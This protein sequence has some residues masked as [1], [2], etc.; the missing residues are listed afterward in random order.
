MLLPNATLLVWL[1]SQGLT[2]AKE[3]CAKGD[4]GACTVI[5]ADRD[6]QGQRVFRSINSC[7]ALLPSL[8]GK[9]V[10]TVEGLAKGGHHPVQQ[11]MTASYGSQCGFC[12]PGFIASLFE[13]Y[14]R[15]EILTNEDLNEQLCGNLCRCTWR[16]GKIRSWHAVRGTQKLFYRLPQN[17]SLFRRNS[18]RD[19]DLESQTRYSQAGK[20]VQGVQAQ[21]DGYQHCCRSVFLNTA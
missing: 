7:I 14:Y 18:P 3:G 12:T 6:L 19:Q 5:V 10:W 20:I 21:R 8:E 13:G 2:G 16:F 9:D 1:R 11:A 4:C 17:R 15:E